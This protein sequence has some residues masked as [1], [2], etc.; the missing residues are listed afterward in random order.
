MFPEAIENSKLWN[1]F[2]KLRA[3]PFL[4]K[5]RINLPLRSFKE[6]L[7]RKNRLVN[8][9]QVLSIMVYLTNRL[10]KVPLLI[11]KFVNA[12]SYFTVSA[13]VL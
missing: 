7:F 13:K 6:W 11:S 10:T 2:L 8:C 1:F 9:F 5:S 4:N 12:L 3:E